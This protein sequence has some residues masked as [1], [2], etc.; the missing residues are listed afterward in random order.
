MET[1][2]DSKSNKEDGKETKMMEQQRKIVK[3]QEET[4]TNWRTNKYKLENKQVQ[5]GERIWCAGQRQADSK[6]FQERKIWDDY[7]EYRGDCEGGGGVNFVIWNFCDRF[8]FVF[9]NMI[10]VV[11]K[12]LML[13]H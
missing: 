2:G 9:L 5:T 3:T 10:D 6:V 11:S 12:H 8:P 7:E 4:S 1:E 13:Q